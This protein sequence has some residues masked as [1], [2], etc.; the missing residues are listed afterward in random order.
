[1]GAMVRP[2]FDLVRLGVLW[3]ALIGGASAASS[4]CGLRTIF[5]GRSNTGTC[6]G[7]CDRYRECSAM[8]APTEH[9]QCLLECPD[10]LGSADNI[11]QF[12]SLECDDVV[13]YVD[14]PRARKRK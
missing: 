14:G 2:R 13:S 8:P 11:R 4:G 6:E 7:A 5:I 12:E 3:L 9:Q 1:M 10:A